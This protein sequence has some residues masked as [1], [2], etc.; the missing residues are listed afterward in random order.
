MV[1]TDF[2]LSI[3]VSYHLLAYFTVFIAIHIFL[4][5]IFIY[6]LIKIIIIDDL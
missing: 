1:S 5:S 3:F 6:Q 4:T 2:Y